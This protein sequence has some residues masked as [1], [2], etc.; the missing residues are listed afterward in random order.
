MSCPPLLC[1]PRRRRQ[2]PNCPGTII[3]LPGQD[4][5]QAH[6]QADRDGGGRVSGRKAQD[7]TGDPSAGR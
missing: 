2:H 5:T 4:C 6:P 3:L 7:R 1:H